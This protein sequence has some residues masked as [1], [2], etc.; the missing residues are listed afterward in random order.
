MDR[1]V[2]IAL[3]A[4]LP[5]LFLIAL[6]LGAIIRFRQPLSRFL[7]ARDTS[8]SAFG[9]RIDLKASDIAEAMRIRSAQVGTLPPLDPT[10]VGTGQ[11]AERAKAAQ[12]ADR[13]AHDFVGG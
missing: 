10:W 1:D 3:V 7:E 5:Q 11:I 13:W 4:Q 9:F 6:A 8:L 12:C 2:L